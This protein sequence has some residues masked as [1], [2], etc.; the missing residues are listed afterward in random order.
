MWRC[1]NCETNNE[2][3]KCPLCGTLRP[4]SDSYTTPPEA[5]DPTRKYS[6]GGMHDEYGHREA[7]SAFGVIGKR[8]NEFH[9]QDELLDTVRSTGWMFVPEEKKSDKTGLY[10]ALGIL[11]FVIVLVIVV[12]SS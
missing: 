1:P 10:L 8:E 9:T 5:L 3:G 12:A 6:Y 2:G 7:K 4:V 11:A